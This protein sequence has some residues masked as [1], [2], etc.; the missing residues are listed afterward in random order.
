MKFLFFAAVLYLSSGGIHFDG[1]EFNTVR[2]NINPQENSL[3]KHIYIFLKELLVL[4]RSNNSFPFY[5]YSPAV[6]MIFQILGA[7]R[8]ISYV[9]G[10]VFPGTIFLFRIALLKTETYPKL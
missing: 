7:S 5:L 8:D 9:Q 2:H 3:G 10:G 4:H 1:G 6:C